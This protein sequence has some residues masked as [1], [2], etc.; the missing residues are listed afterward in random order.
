MSRYTTIQIKKETR[1]D[2]QK[3]CKQ[4]GYKMSSLIEVL[5]N[6]RIKPFTLNRQIKIDPDKVLK[7]NG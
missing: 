2:L 5:I 4:H 6:E 3:Y 1:D 7:V